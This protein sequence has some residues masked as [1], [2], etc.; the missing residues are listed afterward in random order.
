MMELFEEANNFHQIISYLDHNH[1]L[2]IRNEKDNNYFVLAP[3]TENEMFNVK[4]IT[5]EK[6]ISLS[7]PILKHY[8]PTIAHYLGFRF[9]NCILEDRIPI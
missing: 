4:L 7:K 3:A 8:I 6:D 2:F 9:E 5:K 1:K